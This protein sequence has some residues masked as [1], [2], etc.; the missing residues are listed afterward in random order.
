MVFPDSKNI[1]I[2]RT[3]VFSE[4]QMRHLSTISHGLVQCLVW[5]LGGGM[6]THYRPPGR[7]IIDDRS[8]P[9]MAPPRPTRTSPATL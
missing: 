7:I 3:Q 6:A 2:P 9:E 1:T 4:S 5:G 8:N